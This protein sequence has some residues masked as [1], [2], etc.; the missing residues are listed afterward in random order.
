MEDKSVPEQ[1]RVR[2]GGGEG[3]GQVGGGRVESEL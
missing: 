1:L 2:G 3:Q